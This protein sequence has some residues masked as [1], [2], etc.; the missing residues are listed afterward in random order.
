LLIETLKANQILA[1]MHFAAFSTVGESVSDPQK[2][3]DN[4]VSGTLSLLRSMREAGCLKMVFSS[5]G[6][7]YGNQTAPLSGKMQ[8]KIPS[9]RMGLRN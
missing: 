5:T 6:A 2:Y 3:Y 8:P 1:L 9:I 4:N 7:V